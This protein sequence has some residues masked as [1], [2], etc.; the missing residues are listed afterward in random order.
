MNIIYTKNSI[1]STRRAICNTMSLPVNFFRSFSIYENSIMKTDHSQNMISLRHKMSVCKGQNMPLMMKMYCLIYHIRRASR[2]AYYEF[3]VPSEVVK[4]EQY[5]EPVINSAES[6]SVIVKMLASPIH[7][8][9]INT[10]QGTYPIRPKSFPAV[11]GG[12]GIGQVIKV[13]MDVKKLKP[14]DLVFPQGTASIHGASGTWATHIKGRES[15]FDNV[16]LKTQL[17][18][19]KTSIHTA[20]S[21]NLIT[22]LS[23]LRVNPGSALLM[24]KGFVS[25]IKKDDVVIQNGA[26]STVG[27][28]VIQIAKNMGLV[29][30]NIVRDREDINQLKQYLKSIG[31]DHVWTESEL[32][33][34]NDFRNSSLPKARLALNCVGGSCS[35]EIS[36]CLENRGVH[37]TYGGM[38]LKPVTASTSSL[39]FKDITFKGFW[40]SKWVEEHAGTPELKDMYNELESMFLSGKLTVP[41]H[42][43]ISIFDQNAWRSALAQTLKG[44]TSG[45]FILDMRA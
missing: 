38:S 5:V 44:N 8:S 2:L 16:S 33:S 7:P 32:R 43:L 41:K 11:G 23:I 1:L 28:A 15:S 31:A 4:Y 20:R 45:K 34:A 36:K 12:E 35:T 40:F 13:G 18:Y 10:I 42:K 17:E 19:E 25:N 39:I 37:V 9:H 14:R 29:T 21:T 3:G 22:G 26:N 6:G 27:Q 24:L 30:V